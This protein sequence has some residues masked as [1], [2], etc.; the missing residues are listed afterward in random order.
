MGVGGWLHEGEYFMLLMTSQGS[1]TAESLDSRRKSLLCSCN[2]LD[3]ERKDSHG[4]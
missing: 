4:S 2:K 3:F 1:K